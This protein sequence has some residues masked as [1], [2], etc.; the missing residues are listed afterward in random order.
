MDPFADMTVL[1]QSGKAGIGMTKEHVNAIK[2][3]I[4][5]E[6]LDC[7]ERPRRVVKR[8]CHAA[9]EYQELRELGSQ[10]GAWMGSEGIQCKWDVCYSNAYEDIEG[11]FSI[12]TI[13]ASI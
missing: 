5:T 8:Y 11:D 2:L 7:V 3:S 10:L 1:T 13:K 6:L 9:D 4:V 12:L